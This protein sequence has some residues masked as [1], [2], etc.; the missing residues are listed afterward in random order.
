[1]EREEKDEGKEDAMSIDM[2]RRKG[3]EKD[4]GKEDAMIL[5]L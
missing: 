5:I 3:E 1:M 4:E 2:K